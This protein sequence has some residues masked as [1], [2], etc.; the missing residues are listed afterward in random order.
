[1][2]SKGLGAPVGSVLVC[3]KEL[4]PKARRM[5]KVFGGAM[6]QA[7]YLA[8]AGI[9]ALDNHVARL[10]EDHH[11]DQQLGQTLAAQRWVKTIMPV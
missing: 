4:E 10:R 8:A 7:G 9:Y 2:L 11:R 5:R 3:K 1:C 6:R